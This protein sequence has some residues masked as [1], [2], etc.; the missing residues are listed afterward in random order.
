MGNKILRPTE[1]EPF[2]GF[3][4][5]QIS[6]L[7]DKF[8]LLAD[9]NQLLSVEKIASELQTTPEEAGRV[10][11]YI[12]FD[13]QEAVSYYEFVCAAASLHQN[14]GEAREFIFEIYASGK[15]MD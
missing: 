11:L 8:D 13:G 5:D 12:D 6:Y 7:K 2:A 1:L 10:L 15:E 9:E 3:N 14:D 4:D